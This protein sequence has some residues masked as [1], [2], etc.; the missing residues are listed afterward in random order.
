MK[1]KYLVYKTTNNINNFIYIGV[2]KQNSSGFDD[3]LGSGSKLIEAIKEHKH[4]A[5][6]DLH[7]ESCCLRKVL[8]KFKVLQASSLVHG[9][10]STGISPPM[11]T[12]IAC[13][14]SGIRHY[15]RDEQRSVN[16]SR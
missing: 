10:S 12:N 5:W 13:Y 4:K 7:I 3:Y 6:L 11:K 16:H 14:I 2:H 1:T 15:G 8:V 9:L